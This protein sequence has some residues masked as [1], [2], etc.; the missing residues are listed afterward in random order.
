VG[1]P[2]SKIFA[3]TIC[4][5]SA[6]AGVSWR[7]P[8]SWKAVPHTMRIV[9]KLSWNSVLAP[10]WRAPQ[11]DAPF[12]NSFWLFLYWI[13]FRKLSSDVLGR[14]SYELFELR[15]RQWYWLVFAKNISCIACCHIDLDL[16]GARYRKSPTKSSVHCPTLFIAAFFAR[17]MSDS[18]INIIM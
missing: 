16:K 14:R 6:R 5:S 17:R 2:S 15:P 9:V 8:M 4:H 3:S 11:S 13:T 12:S 18:S 7:H 10:L 1:L